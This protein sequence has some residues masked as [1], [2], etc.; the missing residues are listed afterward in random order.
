MDGRTIDPIAGHRRARTRLRAFSTKH[1]MM[2]E[3]C[4]VGRAR[5]AG[6]PSPAWRAGA[7]RCRED[8]DAGGTPECTPGSSS[9]SEGRRCSC[10][11]CTMATR[12]RSARCSSVSASGRAAARFNGPKP[13]L[14]P[15]T[16]SG[17]PADPAATCSSP[18]CRVIRDQPRLRASSATAQR[19]DRIRG[20][21]RA[22]STR[23]RVSPHRGALA[24]PGP[25]G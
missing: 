21:R 19:G 5:S 14:T 9:R 12:P 13:R 24:D 7:A 18:T 2:P 16:S 11:P 10:G 3:R 8:S 6:A 23:H 22:T 20:G 17:S 4:S 1:E 15:A 25:P